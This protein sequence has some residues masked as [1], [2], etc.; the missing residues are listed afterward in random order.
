MTSKTNGRRA[1]RPVPDDFAEHQSRPQSEIA[2]HYGVS[3]YLA[4]RWQNE[5]GAVKAKGGNPTISVPPG[6]VE[7][8]RS[9]LSTKV[10]RVKYHISGQTLRRL[11]GEC[12]LSLR[13]Q[14]VTR[15]LPDDFAAVATKMTRDEL[16]E[17]YR[18][19]WKALNRWIA[20]TGVGPAVR[21]VKQM[22][23]DGFADMAR[24]LNTPRL[25]QIFGVSKSTCARW[26]NELGI[27][28][29][30]HQQPMHGRLYGTRMA[31]RATSST[32]TADAAHFLRRFYRYV[33]KIA[34][35]DVRVR[36]NRNPEN[37][38]IP[39]RGEVKPAE[40]IEMA[41]ARGWRSD[42]TVAS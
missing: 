33:H 6:F 38:L 24:R 18:V 22:I 12:G 27:K 10:I 36:K 3:I 14:H 25:S 13:G 7:D 11:V 35:C 39:G 29:P 4:A 23:P 20:E 2:A 30:E 26:R 32:D 15:E 37:Y 40:L 8:Y 19:G 42:L 5:V 41:R 28:P 34:Y 9:G 1:A 21:P 17:Y 16:R 31:L